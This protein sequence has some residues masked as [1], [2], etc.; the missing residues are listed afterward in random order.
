MDS[1][2]GMGSG[3]TGT[4][5]MP[6]REREQAILAA[7]ADEFAIAGYAGAHVG[8]IAA[9]AEVSKALVLSYFG[10][11]EGLYIAC[12]QR[13]GGTLT[14]A[15]GAAMP[16]LSA[17]T[18]D[19]ERVLDAIFTTLADRPADWPILY[20]RSVPA[21]PA[22]D[23]VR[24]QRTVLRGQAATG[25]G[26]ALASAGLK[27]PDD[28][29]AATLVWEHV[30]SALVQWWLHHPDESAADMTARARRVL[31]AASGRSARA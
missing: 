31:T 20:D 21:G 17:G 3:R 27:D 14:A 12:V 15:I 11:K 2:M 8:A 26:R 29:S 18:A 22:R 4:K 6:R 28:L 30:G 1:V 25:V 24:Q 19:G 5:G 23:A 13:A 7:A 9:A 16:E 10:S